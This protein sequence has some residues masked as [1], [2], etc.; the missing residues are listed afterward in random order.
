MREELS[1]WKLTFIGILMMIYYLICL[2]IMYGAFQ[3]ECC[4]PWRV[5][6]NCKLA[7]WLVTLWKC[8][9]LKKGQHTFQGEKECHLQCW[10]K[11]FISWEGSLHSLQLLI[12]ISAQKKDYFPKVPKCPSKY[13]T[14]F[15]GKDRPQSPNFFHTWTLCNTLQQLQWNTIAAD[16]G[17]KRNRIKSLEQVP[18][19]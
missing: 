5:K 6:S 8:Q 14:W 1:G 13:C 10:K 9:T 18:K 19:N 4:L 15:Q 2:A 7:V 12:S 11:M 3:H 16:H 17:I